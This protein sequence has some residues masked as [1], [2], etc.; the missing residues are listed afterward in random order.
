M[1]ES[2]IE[3]QKKQAENLEDRVN[4]PEKELKSTQEVLHKTLQA[5]ENYL[6][7]DIDGDGV[8]GG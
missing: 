4:E 3:D 7:K 8:T 5:L 6:Q 1:Q 2:K